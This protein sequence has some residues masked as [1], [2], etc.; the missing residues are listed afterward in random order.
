MIKKLFK[1]ACITL[2]VCFVLAAAGLFVLYKMYPPA[3]LKTMAQEY[4]AKNF[5]RQIT[6]DDISFTWIGFTLT[7]VALSENATFQEGTFI[8]AHKLTAHVNVKPLLQKR[9][10]IDTI[11]ADGLQIQLVKQKDGRFNFDTL[12]PQESAPA[13][14]EPAAFSSAGNIPF[15]LTADKIALT[16][17]DISY[18]DQQTGLKTEVNNLNITIRDFD[19]DEA[20]DVLI[21]FTTQISMLG[22]SDMTLPVQIALRTFLADLNLQQAYVTLTEASA[23]YQTVQLKLAGEVKNLENPSVNLSGT[24]TGITSQAFSAFAP[25]LPHFMLPSV[26][27]SLQALAD[28]NT[29]TATISQ[30]KLAVQDT[31]LVAK[32]TVDWGKEIP[33]YQVAATLKANIAQLVQM[34]DTLD[35]FS[36]AGTLSGQF[37]ATEKKNN[38]DVSGTLT[39]TDV[40]VMYDPFTLTQLNGTITL[41]SLEDITAPNLT[42]KLNGQN[43]NM[44]FAYKNVKDVLNLAYQLNLDKLVLAKFPASGEETAATSATDTSV[45]GTSSQPANPTRMNVQ[46]QV[47]IGGI[48]IPY[49]QSQGFTM[50]ANLTNVTDTFNQTNGTVSFMLQPGKIT[51]L[52]NFIKESSVAKI[53]LLPVAVVKRVS[54]FLKLDLFPQAGESGASIAFTEGAGQYTFTNGKMNLDKTPFRSSVTPISASGTADF[55]TEELNMKATATL[56]TQAAPVAIKITGTFNDPKGKLDVVN[57]VT[58]VVGGLLNG[59]AVKSAAKTGANATTDT[60][61]V[62]TDAVKTTVNTA[63][64]LVK[65][66]GGLFKKKKD[67]Q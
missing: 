34:T 2:T 47:T 7:N 54:G 58:K 62:T 67:E 37:K 30:A 59:T 26:S 35:G 55:K 52:D 15:V 44:S 39:L 42:G 50:T 19:L 60:A 43:F 32:G 46:A 41:S 20:F 48:E 8:K 27:L 61:K 14:D 66:I 57:T 16:N 49:L 53:L 23:Q 12:L 25:D 11:E 13:Q 31:S 36:P 18:L 5:Q 24:I 29:S 45:A 64:D 3:K 17:C 33:A 9:I 1:F 28:L 10:E 51:N 63:T 56:L 65:G 6:F 40:S 4:V 38:T 22:Q 21:S